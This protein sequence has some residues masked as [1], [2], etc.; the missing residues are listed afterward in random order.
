[1]PRSVSDKQPAKAQ[2][3]VNGKTATK[4]TLEGI[5]PRSSATMAMIRVLRMRFKYRTAQRAR[6]KDRKL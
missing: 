1:M 2:G 6:R 3:R 5:R 4:R